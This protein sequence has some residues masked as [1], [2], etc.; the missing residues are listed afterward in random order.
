MKT[1]LRTATINGKQ[2]K[3][4]PAFNTE[5]HAHDIEF[6]YNRVSIELHDAAVSSEATARDIERLEKLHDDL[7]EILHWVSYPLTYLP[8]NLY[9][10]A[11]ESIAW[12]GMT[13][14]I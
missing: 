6:R 4:Y 11:K 7:S 3:L 12:A 10:V 8:Y 2:V 14:G 9:L 1:T 13:R 5:K